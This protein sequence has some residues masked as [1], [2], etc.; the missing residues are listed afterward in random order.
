MIGIAIGG[1]FGALA[2]YGFYLLA[3]RGAR[4][5]K[6]ATWL[7]NSVGSLALGLLVGADSSSV[8]WVTGFLGAFTTFSTM[9][10]D[11]VND[12]EEDRLLEAASYLGITLVS[13]ILLFSTAYHLM[14]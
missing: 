11:A 2:R 1:F 12:F 3:E 10:L 7:V 8:F 13:G 14:Q 9:A 6:L 4:Q 5:P